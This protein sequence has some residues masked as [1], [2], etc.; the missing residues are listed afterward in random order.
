MP[1]YDYRCNACEH[2][3]EEFQPITAKP[4]RKCP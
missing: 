4:K 3:W 2:Q 1:T